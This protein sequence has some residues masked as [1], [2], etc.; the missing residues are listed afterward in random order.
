MKLSVKSI[1]FAAMMTIS[2]SSGVAFSGNISPASANNLQFSPN[3]KQSQINPQLQPKLPVCA[4]ASIIGNWKGGLVAAG[5]D[6][7]TSVQIS[8]SPGGAIKQGTW[9][10]LGQTGV[11]EQGTVIAI[12]EGDTVTL[13]LWK[14]E[15]Q[16]KN[17]IVT[18]KG[19]FQ[20]CGH[21]ISGK[22]TDLKTNLVF[23]FA[24][25]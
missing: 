9:K 21:K 23:N 8:V 19:N 22:S 10:F 13:Q 12:V 24:K 11:F 17:K 15:S 25:F 14:Q 4:G 2:V 20:D 18:L 16:S 5:D 7:V 1:A 6:V 3:S